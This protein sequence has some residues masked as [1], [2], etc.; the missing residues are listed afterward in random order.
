MVEAEPDTVITFETTRGSFEIPARLL[1][2]DVDY[3]EEFELRRL[4]ATHLPKPEPGVVVTTS[5][6]ANR[7]GSATVRWRRIVTHVESA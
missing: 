3:L 2:D 6:V 1:A 5:R 4:F 7:D